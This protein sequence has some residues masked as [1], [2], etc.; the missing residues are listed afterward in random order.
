MYMKELI[1][2]IENN[3]NNV[4]AV[5]KVGSN[6][7]GEF[8]FDS[9]DISYADDGQIYI[10]YDGVDITIPTED[11]RVE[12]DEDYNAYTIYTKEMSID[13]IF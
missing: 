9:Y 3:S 7:L 10:R 8:K 6:I 12:Y 5:I 1:D 13:I 4:M 11:A 2:A